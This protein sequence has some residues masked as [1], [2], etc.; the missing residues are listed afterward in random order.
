MSSSSLLP[1]KEVKT[2]FFLTK[3]SLQSLIKHLIRERISDA[4]KKKC[5]SETFAF[6]GIEGAASKWLPPSPV[7]IVVLLTVN[8][9]FLD[10]IWLMRISLEIMF[11]LLYHISRWFWELITPSPLSHISVNVPSRAF[12]HWLILVSRFASKSSFASTWNDPDGMKAEKCDSMYDPWS[13][14]MIRGRVSSRWEIDV[15]RFQIF[16]TWYNG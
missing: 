16:P 11:S 5:C 6:W 13:V 10:F 4:T 8:L 1:M 9:D 12:S 7:N 2:T 3:V 14:K 15:R